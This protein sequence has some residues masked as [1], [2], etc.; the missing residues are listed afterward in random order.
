MRKSCFKVFFTSEN[1]FFDSKSLNSGIIKKMLQ[2]HQIKIL[3]LVYELEKSLSDT[4]RAFNERFQ[5]YHS[6]G[7]GLSGKNRNMP[8]QYKSCTG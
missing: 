4:Y 6:Y 1:G 3:M 5:E 2:D 8:R 7:N